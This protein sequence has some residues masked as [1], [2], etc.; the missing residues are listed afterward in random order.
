LSGEVKL[1]RK[2][3]SFSMKERMSGMAWRILRQTV[4]AEAKGEADQTSGIDPHR[5]RPPGRHAAA[6]SSIHP[7]C[8][9]VRHPCPG[10]TVAR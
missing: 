3:M 5:R 2:R 1:R 6:A 4:D 8:E 9:Q 10:Q 7:V